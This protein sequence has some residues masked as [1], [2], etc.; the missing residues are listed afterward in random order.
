GRS[1]TRPDPRLVAIAANAQREILPLPRGAE[2]SSTREGHPF[3]ST[4]LDRQGSFTKR[5]QGGTAQNIWRFDAGSE[6]VPLAGDWPGTSRKPM[7]LEGRGYFLPGR[8][9]GKKVFSVGPRG[10]DPEKHTP[11]PGRGGSTAVAAQGR[12]GGSWRAG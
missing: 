9:G 5:Y 8:G 3:F 12:G 2:G 10:A 6:A 7:F 11:P 1:P 4:R